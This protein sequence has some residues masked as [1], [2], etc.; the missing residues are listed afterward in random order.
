MFGVPQTHE[1]DAERAVRRPLGAIENAVTEAA[2]SLGI[3]LEAEVYGEY[4]RLSLATLVYVPAGRWKDADAVLAEGEAHAA[5]TSRLVWLWLVTGLAL[6]R[7]DL[8]LTD[9]YLPEF[10]ETAL[11]SEEP[12]RIVPM[13]GV[14]IPRALIAGE[15]AAITDLADVLLTLPIRGF[16]TATSLLAIARSL[17]ALGERD[18]LEQLVRISVM[19]A[20]AEPHASLKVAN[21]LLARLDG[22]AEEARRLLFE[23]V[24]ELDGLGRHYDA[25]CAALEAAATADACGDA[26]SAQAMRDRAEPFLER[27]AC[28]NAF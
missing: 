26:E 1:D 8:E 2:R 17:V 16:V 24:D 15:T 20:V 13:A 27:L 25:A 22:R 28:V 18:R 10:R 6:R 23:G 11:A 3:G 5:V 19:P 14:A 9:R 7:G 4:L 12:Q 21:G